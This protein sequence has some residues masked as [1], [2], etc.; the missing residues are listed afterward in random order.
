MWVI[1][2]SVLSSFK[3]QHGIN[4]VRHLLQAFSSTEKWSQKTGVKV[5]WD[6]WLYEGTSKANQK[7]QSIFSHFQSENLPFSWND[8]VWTCWRR[9]ARG[10]LGNRE[11]Y[12]VVGDCQVRWTHMMGDRQS[13]HSAWECS[14][15]VI[16]LSKASGELQ[17]QQV[18]DVTL[19]TMWLMDSTLLCTWRRAGSHAAHAQ[20]RSLCW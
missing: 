20:E 15:S 12:S 7:S 4:R 9:R 17:P 11:K 5:T 2:W 10:G 13:S 3:S 19:V 14:K 8:F 16:L 1:V 18:R 6:L